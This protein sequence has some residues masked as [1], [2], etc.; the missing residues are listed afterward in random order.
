MVAGAV[1]LTVGS[2]LAKVLKSSCEQSG[3]EMRKCQ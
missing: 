2:N 3:L 1:V